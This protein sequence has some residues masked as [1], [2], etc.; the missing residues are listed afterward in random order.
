[1]R[2]LNRMRTMRSAGGS[3]KSLLRVTGIKMCNPTN[4]GFICLVR[5]MTYFQN[6][7]GKSIFSIFTNSIISVIVTDFGPLGLAHMLIPSFLPC[8]LCH[9]DIYTTRFRMSMTIDSPD[10]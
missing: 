2:I 1:M 7:M 9:T 4:F 5:A 3:I 10:N 6:F 8:F